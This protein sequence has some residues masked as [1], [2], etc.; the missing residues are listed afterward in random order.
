MAQPLA[1]LDQKFKS[2]QQW[3]KLTQR[4]K[5]L[6][7]LIKNRHVFLTTIISPAGFGKSTLLSQYLIELELIKETKVVWIA[8]DPSDNEP[9]QFLNLLCHGLLFNN[10]ADQSLITKANSMSANMD[11]DALCHNIINLIELSGQNI[12]V[13]FDDFHFISH[14]VIIKFIN[15]LIQY[16]PSGLHL[17]ISTRIQPKLDISQLMVTGQLFAIGA[18]ELKFSAQESKQLLM[19]IC[20]EQKISEIYQRTEGWP[21]ALQLILLWHQQHPNVNFDQLIANNTETL[22]RYMA[23]QIF[24]VLS[25]E[26]QNFLL[27]TAFLDRFDMELANYVCEIDNSN[28]L[29]GQLGDYCS[30]ITALDHEQQ[31]FRYHHLFSDFL[32]LSLKFKVGQ[33][34]CNELRCRAAQY[35]ADHNH[36]NEAVSQSIRAKSPELAIKFI[37]QAKGWEMIL[38]RGI[39]YAEALL[40]HFTVAQITNSPALGLLQSYF[41]MKL[42]QVKQAEQQFSLAS[43]VHQNIIDV[44][45]TSDASAC[46]FLVMTMLKELY[47]DLGVLPGVIERLHQDIASLAVTDHLARGTMAAGLAL[48]YN[49][50]GEF[51]LAEATALTSE[52]EMRL[53]NCWVGLNYILLHHGQSLIYRGHLPQAL[54]QFNQASELAEKHLGMDNGLKRMTD[55]L[56]AELHFQQH[57]YG[58]SKQLLEQS[59]SILE[60]KD[61]WHDIY[62]V[63]FKLAINLAIN[64]QDKD[65]ALQYIKRGYEVVHSRNLWR[66]EK[67]LDILKLKVAVC[68]GD[69]EQFNQINSLIIREPYWD[70]TAAM[71]QQITEYYWV[72]ALHYFKRDISNQTLSYCSKLLALANKTQQNIYIARV[73]ALESLIHW[74]AQHEKKSLDSLQQALNLCVEYSFRSVF[75]ELPQTLELPLI[76][77][78]TNAAEFKLSS[79][80]IELI[81][82]ILGQL[83]QDE[84][85]AY[86]KLGLS[87]REL[88]IVPHLITGMTNKQI[89]AELGITH[90]TVKFHLKNLFIKLKVTNRN[91]AMSVLL[92]QG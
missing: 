70:D 46:D 89:S 20:S 31:Y 14:P 13:F 33:Q 62:A 12:Y 27:K 22:N 36:L 10:L 57:Q 7:R 61:C 45:K 5:L 84:P 41:Y 68:F 83:Q 50:I 73:K 59:I 91:E 19:D 23:Q 9:N 24:D 16:Q 56:K 65:A 90:Y 44:G 42:G 39:G 1:I 64:D 43:A 52:R 15:K 77:L 66:L 32:Q 69:V 47:L 34:G 35:F 63:S 82:Y 40:N 87:H 78:K 28:E 26:L 85:T 80:D 81:S 86:D 38:T 79:D 2:P 92:S 48:F 72:M 76:K 71:W 67:L 30:L 54:T 37:V 75:F 29:L 11:F 55:C 53:A 74:R 58:I 51:E 49:Q 88:Q 60:R 8:L 21:V 4:D 17:I 18:P 25:D 6:G 3:V